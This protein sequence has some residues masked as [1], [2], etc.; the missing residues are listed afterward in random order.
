MGSTDVPS[1]SMVD[2]EVGFTDIEKYIMSFPPKTKLVR[3]HDAWLT[4]GDLECLLQDGRW[5]DG[6][7]S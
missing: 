6:D 4:R 5:V 7:V 1:E 3:I 2:T